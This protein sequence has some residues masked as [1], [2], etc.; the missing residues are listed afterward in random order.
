MTD[1]TMSI[2][3]HDVTPDQAAALMAVVSG[4]AAPAEK[5]KS[6]RRNAAAK[7]KEA[8]KPDPAPAKDGSADSDDGGTPEYTLDDVREALKTYR[9]EHSKEA[10]EGIIKGTGSSNIS[11]IPEDKF[12][13]VI[14]QCSK[15]PDEGGS[16]E[17]DWD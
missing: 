4:D 17:E 16:D 12:A 1:A 6:T 9:G 8:E 3:F 7:P 2:T 5:P 13:W 14:E 10:A 11:G 15:A